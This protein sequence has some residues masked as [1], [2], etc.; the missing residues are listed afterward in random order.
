MKISDVV[1]KEVES[2]INAFNKKNGSQYMA[3]YRGKFL[4][5]DKYDAHICRLTFTGDM[6]NWDFAVYKY[7]SEKYDPDEW[8]FPGAGHVDGSIEGA[9]MAGLELYC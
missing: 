4:Y 5:L 2:K 6:N 9:M 3:K 7:S 1:K 8:F